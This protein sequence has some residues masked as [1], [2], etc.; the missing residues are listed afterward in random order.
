MVKGF[1]DLKEALEKIKNSAN[2]QI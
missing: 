2:G 1:H